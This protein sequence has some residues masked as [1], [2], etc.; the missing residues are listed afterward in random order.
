MSLEHM[1]ARSLR[2]AVRTEEERAWVGFYQR[3]GRD[4]A[5]AAEV[6]AQLEADPEMKRLHLGLYLSCRQALRRHKERQARHKRVGQLLRA[7][8]RV[9]LVGPFLALRAALVGS[10]DLLL[11]SLPQPRA[12]PAAAQAR[13]LARRTEFAATRAGFDRDE[14]P[15]SLASAPAETESARRTLRASA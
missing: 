12:E 7:W 5:T 14:A 9:L 2:S 10:R 6:M 15:P 8:S 3:V 13:R 4:P 11:E 1:P